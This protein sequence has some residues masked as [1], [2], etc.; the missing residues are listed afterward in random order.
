ME[1][2][3][4]NITAIQKAL[5]T[6]LNT[7]VSEYYVPSLGRKVGFKPLV[8]A[9]C[10][11]LAKMLIESNEKPFDTFKVTIGMIKETCMDDSVDINQLTELDRI[12]ILMEFYRSNNILKDFNVDCPHCKKKTLLKIN[13]GDTIA[14]METFDTKDVLFDN[15]QTNRLTAKLKLPKLTT[16]YR[17][18]EGVQ[19]KSLTFEDM[20]KCFIEDIKESL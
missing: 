15:G 5:Q 16:M 7:N 2:T 17:F 18:Y 11:T 20:M 14:R 8:T 12:K 1:Q 9:Q 13:I 3:K 19:N 6:G 10:K 4:M